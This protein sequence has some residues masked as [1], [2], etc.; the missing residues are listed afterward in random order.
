MLGATGNIVSIHSRFQEQYLAAIEAWAGERGEC[1]CDDE[2]GEDHL[3]GHCL[4]VPRCYPET[5]FSHVD[6]LGK[7]KI[8]PRI[9]TL[10]LRVP[11]STLQ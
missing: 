2:R 6:A 9:Q 7:K 5:G 4:S 10:G 3:V 11:T 8:G 1:E